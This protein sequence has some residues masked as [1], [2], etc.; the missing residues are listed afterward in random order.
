MTEKVKRC[1]KKWKNIF[2]IQRTHNYKLIRKIMSTRFFKWPKSWTFP[3]KRRLQMANKPKK[4]CFIS[5]STWGF[6]IN[7]TTRYAYTPIRMV[8]FFYNKKTDTSKCWQG[9]RA[10]TALTLL[11]G[12][13]VGTDTL[14]NCLSVSTK[15]ECIVHPITQ[16]FQFCIYIQQ[17]C[18][19]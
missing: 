2:S 18:L 3:C 7:I 10:T 12:G 9:G 13:Y 6:Q 4:M 19:H 14:E 15:A 8:N 11:V 17:K 1:T 5:L 16:W